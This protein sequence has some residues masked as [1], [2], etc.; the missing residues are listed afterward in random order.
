MG[1]G[2]IHCQ[3]KHGQNK[4]MAPQRAWL[5]CVAQRL[6]DGTYGFEAPDWN[7]IPH[8]EVEDQTIDRQSYTPKLANSSIP[9]AAVKQIA[10]YRQAPSW[11]TSSPQSVAR[12]YAEQLLMRVCHERSCWEKGCNTFLSSLALG[13]MV[14][15][16]KGTD[17]W[18]YAVED[19]GQCAVLCWPMT[20]FV[21]ADE[22]GT[23]D[24]D[25]VFEPAS[26][27][28]RLDAMPVF[29]FDADDYEAQ[30]VQWRS[31]LHMAMQLGVTTTI[32][33]AAVG[34]PD[35]LLRVAATRCFSSMGLQSLRK[36]RGH[37][38]LDGADA[39]LLDE[40]VRLVS[41][42][43]KIAEGDPLMHEILARRLEAT[44]LL[45]E[46]FETDIVEQLVHHEAAALLSCKTSTSKQVSWTHICQA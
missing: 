23:F 34:E 9:I 40:L 16:R 3:D 27:V 31:P 36:L 46:F 13:D 25:I 18:M 29:I 6:V 42:A 1:Y 38:G 5:S 37:Y 20:P 2:C 8:N 14:F 44:E 21:L 45:A 43:L 11:P 4:T 10:S 24:A 17:A 30:Q 15:R 12:I 35:S 26:S 32:V 41:W 39:P 28:S 22:L 33:L 7:N 19:L